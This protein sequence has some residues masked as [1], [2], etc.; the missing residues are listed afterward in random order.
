MISRAKNELS[1]LMP[2]LNL[3]EVDNGIIQ[4]QQLCFGLANRSG[5]W[6]DPYSGLPYTVEQ[7]NIPEKLCLIHSELSEAMEGHRKNLKD[8]HLPHRQMLE[9]EL[10]DAVIRVFDLAGWLKLDLSGAII[11]KLAYNQKRADHK[12]ENRAKADGK[13][14]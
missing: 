3:A 14:F 10:A 9:V 13:K 5:W 1:A 4:T 7:V 6:T 11:E 8:D 2:A 12:L